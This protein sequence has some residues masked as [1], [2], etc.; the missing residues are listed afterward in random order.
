MSST[1]FSACFK[2]LKMQKHTNRDLNGTAAMQ[3][4]V[5]ALQKVKHGLTPKYSNSMSEY[6]QERVESR[7]LNGYLHSHVRSRIIHNRPRM[8]TAQMSII[9][10]IEEQNVVHLME[11]YSATKRMEILTPATTW[12]DFEDLMLSEINQKDTHCLIPLMGSP[13]RSQM[14]RDRK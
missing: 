3:N 12:M 13:W 5:T 1:Y 10:W 2:F 11:Y 6:R 7:D 14:H 9:R 8:E 4:I